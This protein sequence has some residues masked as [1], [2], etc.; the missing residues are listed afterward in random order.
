M[1]RSK[2]R[3]QRKREKESVKQAVKYLFLIFLVLFLMVRFGLPGLIKLAAFIGDIKSSN[4]PIEKQDQLAPRPPTL[5]PISEATTSAKINLSGYGEAG[6]TTQLYVRG[7]TVADSVVNNEG[8]FEFLEVH[9]REGENEI[10]VVS[11]DDQGNVSD[12]S[13]TYAITVDK[14][15]PDLSIESP[16]DG[17]NF[18]DNDNPI[19]IKGTTEEGAEVR[20]N[21]RFTRTKSDGS[22]ETSLSLD[23]GDN[24]IEIKVVDEAG[25]ETVE[26]IKV[27][28]AP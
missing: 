14:T 12:E 10:Y 15:A 20:V 18:F 19:T 7:I 13:I 9:L 6:T 21:N 16:K 25:N 22:F 11:R 5:N 17:D 23:E 4:Q 28:Y 3:L 26:K 2:T 8:E 27:N 1:G 24:E